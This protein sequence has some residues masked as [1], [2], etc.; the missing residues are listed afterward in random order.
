MTAVNEVVRIRSIANGGDGVA[1]LS[2]GRTVF[3]PR[4]APGDEV[5]LR[6]VRMY[7]RYARASA[8]ELLSAGP[9][10]TAVPCPHYVADRCGGCQLMHLDLAT[11]RSVKSRIIG[12][13]LR[14]IARLEVA[15]PEVIAAP[16]S[17]GY[18]TKVTFTVSDGV[19]GF[20][21]LSEAGS[22]FEVRRCL[23]M[24][25]RLDAL[26]QQLRGAR[27][28]LPPDAEQVVLRLDG[29]AG[30]HLLVRTRGDQAW[31][32]AEEFAARMPAGTVVW[33]HPADGVPRSVAG[34]DTRWPATVFEQVHPAMAQVIRRRAVEALLDGVAPEAM[35]WDLYAGI[36][37]T[38]AL[39]AAAGCRVSSVELDPLAVELAT[40]LG[41]AGPDRRAGD[42]AR[43]VAGLPA[44]EVVLANPPRTGMAAEA[45]VAMG[46]S[47]AVRIAYISCDPATLARDIRVLGEGWKLGSVTGFDQF[48]ETA[49]VEV[50]AILESADR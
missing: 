30:R 49:H 41:P 34:N 38:T 3:V 9:G 17:L 28:L 16:A 39:L 14:R 15:D 6:D 5:R 46:R 40:R 1:T 32:D 42:V 44:P 13:A 7:R 12:D 27:A 48:P 35:A 20:H 8:S 4:T 19:I 18:R 43:L 31:T 33:W 45:V 11:Q 26:H 25:Q 23:L 36:G 2:D 37:E 21:R 22:V 29:Q 24:D 47:G 10:R 50:L